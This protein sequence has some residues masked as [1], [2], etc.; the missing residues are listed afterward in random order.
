MNAKSVQ[1]G[2][3][4]P[5]RP[6]R[7]LGPIDES[8]VG[9][10]R[11][12]LEALRESFLRR[13]LT[14]SDLSARSGFSRSKIS[15]LLRGTGLYPR[16]EITYSLL[17]ILEMP[18]WPVQ[19][20][21]IAGAREAQ[22][23]PEWIDGCIK[24]VAVSIGPASPPMAHRAFKEFHASTYHAYAAAFLRGDTEAALAVGETFDML[25][26][27]WD[28]AV[29]SAD[30]VKFAWQ[31]LRRNVMARTVHTDGY[32][33][34]ARAA[35]GT[36][37]VRNMTG[38]TE[39]FAQIGETMALFTAMSR[40]PDHQ[41]DVMVLKYLRGRSDAAVADVLGVPVVAVSTADHYAQQYLTTALR[42]E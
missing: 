39:R 1:P 4:P 2:G 36:V 30:V 16:W 19:R 37:A 17:H 12:W 23:K 32:P 31:V 41:L 38:A 8:V 34:L 29:A 33:E 10:H 24:K 11:V 18:T 21:W 9:T 26:L 13:G 20:M 3:V 22:K 14:I 27:R 42:S 7:K 25:W 35:F 15:E 28:E 40:L 5:S 6:G